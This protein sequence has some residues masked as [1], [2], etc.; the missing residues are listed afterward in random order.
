MRMYA[1]Y[2]QSRK[3][4]A[5]YIVVAVAILIGACV[6]LD[7]TRNQYLTSIPFLILCYTVG[8]AERKKRKTSERA[9]ANWLRSKYKSRK[10]NTSP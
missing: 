8:D 9:G 3:V 4:L 6:S 10:V 2:E 5:L 1:L 7:F